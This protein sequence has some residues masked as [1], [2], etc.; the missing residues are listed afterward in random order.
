[1]DKSQALASL[2]Q[3]D[4]SS[5]NERADRFAELSD[6]LEGGFVSFHGDQANALFDDVKA[7]WIAGFFVAT[8]VCADAFCKLQLAGLLRLH[9]KLLLPAGGAA[10]S[11]E[12]LAQRA[13]DQ[14]LIDEDAQ[15]LC[16]ELSDR[17]QDFVDTQ[18]PV[19]NR[20]YNRHLDDNLKFEEEPALL[21]AARQALA[22][23]IAMARTG[24]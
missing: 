14:G 20:R 4:E 11:F 8:I 6:R 1:M 13:T 24:L 16:F 17:S 9:G 15:A 3:F 23:S 12:E 2:S 10:F 7:T 5:I 21:T 18:A 19:L 22:A